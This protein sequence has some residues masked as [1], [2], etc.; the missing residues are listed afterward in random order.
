VGT[1]DE[2]PDPADPADPAELALDLD[3]P[4]LVE[5]VERDLLGGPREFTRAQVAERA[6]VEPSDARELWQALGFAA[7]D[8]DE[9]AFTTADIEAIGRVRELKADLGV[10]DDLLR[11][12]TRML[13]RS[14]S[15]LASWQGQLLIEM[16]SSSPDLLRSEDELIEFL[17]RLLA[18]MERIQSYVWRRQLAAYL[19][20]V[21]SSTAGGTTTKAV[22]FAD[23]AAFTAFTRRSSEA[24]L[25][26]VLETF[27]SVATDIVGGHRGQIVKTIGDE[28]LYVADDPRD[29]AEIALAL[30]ETAERDDRLPALRVGV[31]AGPVV[32]RLGDVFGQTVNIASRL[33]SIA[34]TGSILVDEGMVEVLDGD[35]RY[36]LKSLRP[37]SVRGY[38]HLRSWRLRRGD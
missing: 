38:H 2:P 12:M 30:V 20:R 3:V 34:R 8:D 17:D 13:G 14:F 37:T 9:R 15:R 11:A 4:A 6:D 28:V 5:R 19:S 7:V 23:M 22:G 24:E 33:T 35:G 32:S 10:D 25:R 21:T 29:G 18:E 31:A 36:A 1:G 26:T 27:E 16:L